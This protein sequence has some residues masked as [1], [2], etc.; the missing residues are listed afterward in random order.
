MDALTTQHHLMPVPASVEFGKARFPVLSS[1]TVGLKGHTDAR[2]TAAID[3]AMRRLEGRTGFVFDRK[4]APDPDSA[5]LLIHARAA[6]HTIPSVDENESYKLEVTGSRVSLEAPTVVG[7]IRGLETLLQLLE[8][9]RQGYFLPEVRI[10]DKPRF[11]WRGLLVDSARHFQPVEV[12]KRTLDGMAAVKMNVLHWHLTEDQGFRIESR[13]YPKLHQMGSDGVYYTQEQA[14]EVIE[15]ARGRG[16]RVVPEFDMPGHVTSWLVGHPELASLPGPYEIE[17]RPGIM[18]PS[19]DPTREEVYKFLD[20]FLGEM[21]ALFPDAY[22]HIGGDENEGK[23]W[24]KNPKIQE[25]MKQKSFKDNHALQAYFNQRVSKIL[26]KYKKR[27]VGWDEILHPDLPNNVVIQS[28]RGPKALAEAARKGYDGILSNGYYI[29]LIFPAE[30]H[31]RV[32]PIPADSHLTE[33]EMA[34]VL[35]GEATMWSEWV[36]PETIDSRIWPR[37]AAI[38]ERFWSPRS[39]TDIDDMY[40]RLAVTSTRLEELGLTHKRNQD[41][42]LRRLANGA[43]I[44]SLKTLVSVIEPVKEYRRNQMRPGTMLTPLTGLIDA[45]VPDAEA[46]RSFPAQVNGFVGDAPRFHA[47]KEN[48]QRTFTE[49]RDSGPA[50]EIILTQSPGLREAEPL[51]KDLVRLGEIGLEAL[52]YV[53]HGVIPSAD[54]RDSRMAVIQEANKPKAALEFV[55]I[56]GMTKLVVAAAELQQLNDSSPAD[57]QKRVDAVAKEIQ[58]KRP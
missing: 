45:A 31:Y 50:L 12:L 55:V 49:W 51:M 46:R 16:I 8:A 35:G 19:L 32:D 36:S 52:S 58:P 15:Y 39:V 25:F 37:T 47:Y 27:M 17:R 4:F 5:S 53:S 44:G 10:D 14:R 43:E 2:L 33:R 26:T 57:W 34:H 3:R 42:M 13:K 38:A 11:R 24:D 48:L 21:A 41:M 7:V 54:W 40:R 23:H 56:S 18:D 29:D 28:W 1:F 9:D 30:D 6:G 22:M 20:V